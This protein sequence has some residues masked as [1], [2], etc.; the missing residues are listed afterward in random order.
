[1]LIN[2]LNPS[3][4]IFY[5]SCQGSGLVFPLFHWFGFESSTLIQ[6]HFRNETE[7]C[8][9]LL[10]IINTTHDITDKRVSDSAERVHV[11]SLLPLRMVTEVLKSFD[12][13]LVVLQHFRNI[14]KSITRMY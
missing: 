9:L 8:F 2:I 11:S 10:N 12:Y 7:M 13:I 1:M 14:C 4:V 6:L 3:L 5:L